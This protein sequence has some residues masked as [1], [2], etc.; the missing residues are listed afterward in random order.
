[1]RSHAITN[2]RY[3]S[4]PSQ[5]VV[6]V[7]AIPVQLVGISASAF[8]AMTSPVAESTLPPAAG[9]PDVLANY[10]AEINRISSGALL[11]LNQATD[12]EMQQNQIR[13]EIARF[14]MLNLRCAQIIQYN[15]DTI[16]SLEEKSRKI[17]ESITLAKR[18]EVEKLTTELNR[19]T[20]LATERERQNNLLQEEVLR[21]AHNE[22][23]LN[24]DIER[25]T[26][27]L[28]AYHR[29]LNLAYQDIAKQEN[30][31]LE[32]RDQV[33][34]LT[35]QKD[36]AEA[37]FQ[38]TQQELQRIHNLLNNRSKLER[39]FFPIIIEGKKDLKHSEKSPSKAAEGSSFCPQ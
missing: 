2:N 30:R 16:A 38:T 37:A 39:V 1:M 28:R 18:A 21:T 7:Q 36:T 8:R 24:Q 31:L 35:R 22:S 19:L 3:V 33:N 27:T 10:I 29:R 23:R 34:E 11:E 32:L 9:N 5:N 14:N 26:N 25:L 6:S 4:F 12:P 15:V 13:A 17:D 20:A